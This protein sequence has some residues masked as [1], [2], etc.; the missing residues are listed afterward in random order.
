MTLYPCT[1]GN[2]PHAAPAVDPRVTEVKTT[3]ETGQV[4]KKTFSYDQYNNVTDIFEYDYGNGQA[5]QLLLRTHTDYVTDANYTN[6]TV[7]YL[8][9]LPSQSWVSSDLNGSNKTSFSQFEYDNY[10]SDSNHALLVSR[11]NVSGFDANYTTTYTWRGNPTSVTSFAKAQNQTEPITS[12]SQY[13]I[14]GNLVKSIDARGFA[15]TIDYSDRFGTPSGEAR[16]NWDIIPVPAQLNGLSTFA[17]ATSATNTLGH[18]TNTLWHTTYAQYD[19]ST[20]LVVDAEDINE[21]VNTS[22]YNDALDRQTQ[23]ITANNRPS[24]RLQKT[25]AFDD[26]AHKLTVTSDLYSFGDNLS[27]TESLFNSLGQN[28]ETRKYEAGGHIASKTEYDA[29][30]RVVKSSNPY[31][32][33]LGESPIWTVTDYDSLSRVVK[34][35]TPDNSEA[36]TSYS[37]NLTTVTDQAGKKRRSIVNALGQLIRLDEPNNQ[38]ELGASETPIQPTFYTYNTNGQMVKATQGGQS[39]Y[40]LYDSIGRLLRVRQPEQDANPALAFSDPVTGNSQWSNGSTYDANGNVINTTDAKGVVITM[41]YDILNRV[42]TR[43]YSDSTPAV[44]YTYENSNIAF[45]KGQLTKVSST[46]SMTEYTSFDSLGKVLS[47]KQTTNGQS[48]TTAYSYNLSGALVEETYPSGRVVK[49]AFNA[50]ARLTAVSSKAVTQS[51][52]HTYANNFAY[53]A[54]GAVKQMRLGN[55]TWES[56]QFNPRL[57][58]TQIALGTS[59][60]ASNLWKTVYEYG[61][62]DAYENLQT[63]RNSGNIARQTINFS[64]LSKPYV[65]T[66]KYDSLNRLSEATEKSDTTQTWHQTFAYDRYG[67]RT[68]FSQQKIGEPAITQTPTIDPATN[69]LTTAQGYVYD[70]NGNLTQDNLNR[71]FI[72]NGD[73]K[74]VEVKDAS[75][76]VLGQYYYD[77]SGLRVKKVTPLET[78]IFVYNASGN[79]VA[80]YSTQELANPTISY[81]TS[82]N[83]GSPRVLTDSA[84]AIASRRDFM[85]FGEELYAGT[86]NR[87]EAHHFGYGNDKVRKRFT[88]YEKD[89]ETGLDFAEARYYDNRYGRFTAVDPLLASGKS[90]DPQ[91]FNRYAYVMN[92]P[93]IMTDSTGMWSDREWQTVDSGLFDDGPSVR[94]PIQYREYKMSIGLKQQPKTPPT[95]TESTAASQPPSTLEEQGIQNLNNTLREIALARFRRSLDAIGTGEEVPDSET[96]SYNCVAEGFYITDRW[97]QPG[98]NGIIGPLVSAKRDSDGK[99]VGRPTVLSSKIY[100]YNEIPTFFGGTLLA[101]GDVCAAGTYQ[102]RI[103]TDSTYLNEPVNTSFPHYGETLPREYKNGTVHVMRQMSPGSPLWTSKNGA[104]SRYINIVDPNSFYRYHYSPVG[105]VTITNYCMPA[106]RP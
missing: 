92:N 98:Y 49:H 30:G 66:Y 24:L 72:F 19:Y 29:L 16:G 27:K 5:G 26:F 79:L 53:T 104:Q 74:Q 96:Y 1:D 89:I 63:D 6:Y 14:L 55:G 94:F 33:Y 52:F 39:R 88:G 68:G 76:N 42:S 7:S 86:A 23:I 69:R 91:S 65:Q 99:Q 35:K 95:Q 59:Q 106:R 71:Q 25:Y 56:T 70:L 87:L 80:E 15:R 100:Y 61:E 64:G 22:F 8:L 57:Q 12:Y 62:F 50:D 11:S 51:A 13:D 93:V 4:T 47:H 10:N 45:S 3:L 75:N 31:R 54:A 20:G 18:T 58:V 38:N 77:G 78:V 73:N 67:N 28:T 84:G 41:T 102:L 60:H 21:N 82:D 85:P 83:L 9:R 36:L 37:G 34:V 32:L 40:F 2:D 105:T 46:V 101:E 97:V 90:A 103:F 43:S 81:L 44:T 17:F 48:Y